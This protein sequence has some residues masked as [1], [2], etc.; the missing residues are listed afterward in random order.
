MSWKQVN[1]LKTPSHHIRKLTCVVIPAIILEKSI[2]Q[3]LVS[4]L[5]Y[6]YEISDRT[7]SSLQLEELMKNT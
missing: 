6:Q 1:S 5:L 4:Q 2:Y 3:V 7:R